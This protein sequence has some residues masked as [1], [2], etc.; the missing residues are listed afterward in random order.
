MRQ[1]QLA[2]TLK[3]DFHIDPSR[4]FSLDN[5]LIDRI[6]AL[7]GNELEFMRTVLASYLERSNNA[8]Q[9]NTAAASS[10]LAINS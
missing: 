1:Q 7:F 10:G 8:T 5:F 3:A 4:L 6:K 2:K 9:A